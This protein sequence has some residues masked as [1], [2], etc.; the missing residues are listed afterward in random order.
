MFFPFILCSNV[1]VKENTRIINSTTLICVPKEIIF[2][3]TEIFP[4]MHIVKH[5]FTETETVLFVKTKQRTEFQESLVVVPEASYFY[6][7]MN[8]FLFNAATKTIIE[9]S[10]TSVTETTTSVFTDLVTITLTTNTSIFT[11][12]KKDKLSITRIES[13]P[14]TLTKTSKE[15]ILGTSIETKTITDVIFIETTLLMN[16]TV[17]SE[18]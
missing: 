16:E 1:V 18:I 17:T 11:T 6:E 2:T 9:S 3:K 13:N 8:M 12:I 15:F 10:F 14:E 5:F 4:Q 7:D